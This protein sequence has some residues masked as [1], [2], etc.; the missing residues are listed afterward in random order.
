MQVL[1]DLKEIGVTPFTKQ[2]LAEPV[3]NDLLCKNRL[4]DDDLI[5]LGI[6]H[7]VSGTCTDPEMSFDT[8][9]GD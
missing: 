1:R 6:N 2:Y 5:R 8:W 7:R 9:L 4:V 3:E